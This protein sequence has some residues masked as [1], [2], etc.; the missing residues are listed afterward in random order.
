VIKESDLRVSVI[1]EAKK[2]RADGESAIK[3]QGHRKK[4]FKRKRGGLK[5]GGQKQASYTERS[6]QTATT[7]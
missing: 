6:I 7:R 4:E 2:R 1:A 3:S 5:E